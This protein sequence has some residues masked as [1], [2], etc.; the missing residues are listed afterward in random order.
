[1]TTTNQELLHKEVNATMANSLLNT[2]I[3]S[4]MATSDWIRSKVFPD[5]LLPVPFND[6]C[7]DD[8][9]ECWDLSSQKFSNFLEA[10]IEQTVQDWLNH[11]AH[12][13]GVK[14]NLI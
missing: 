10:T 5:E 14:H 6:K 13:L 4:N 7:L 12:T 3:P 11:L 1:M 2:V 9:K 8:V